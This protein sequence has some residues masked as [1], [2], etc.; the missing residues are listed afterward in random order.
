MEKQVF[1]VG[2]VVQLK[3]DHRFSMTVIQIISP[4]LIQVFWL[5]KAGKR[6]AD[7]FHPD[8]LKKY[9]EKQ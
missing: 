2:D 7:A 5:T 9:E 1:K 6:L 3:G 4:H 8:A